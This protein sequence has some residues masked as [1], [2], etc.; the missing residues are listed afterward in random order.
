LGAAIACHGRANLPAVIVIGNG[1]DP[2]AHVGDVRRRRTGCSRL[3]ATWCQ[4]TGKPAAG[5]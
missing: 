1:H 4:R 2:A 3:S 5:V